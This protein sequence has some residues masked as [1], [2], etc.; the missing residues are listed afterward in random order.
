MSINK[1]Q[2]TQLEN[3]LDMYLQDLLAMSDKEVLDGAD[4]AALKAE[5]LRMLDS[6]KVEA[7]RRRLTAA[8]SRMASAPIAIAEQAQNIS[9]SE[10]RAYLKK[11]ANDPR[12]TLAARELSE[13]SDM[14][15]IWLYQQIRHLEEQSDNGSGGST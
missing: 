14:D 8:Q 12:F 10:A 11:A 3:F 4:P 5:G 15:V 2:K 6:A 1:S 13:M 9:A 7:G